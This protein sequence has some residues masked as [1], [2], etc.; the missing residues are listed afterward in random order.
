[1]KT[2]AGQLRGAGGVAG[3]DETRQ[4]VDF[5]ATHD[6]AC[7]LCGYNLRALTAPRCPECGREVR[8]SVAMA[9]PYLRAW[10][11]L[12]AATCAAGGAGM[13]LLMI[14]AVEGW[15][16]LGQSEWEHFFS[17]A[18]MVY[19]I[20]GVPLAAAVLVARR[21]LLRLTARRQWALAWA[22]VVLTTAAMLAFASL[23]R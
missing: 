13:F 11:V 17:N 12:A 5:L 22:A 4:L 6:A 19:F 9:E 15:P 14:V 1:V 20:G 10:V 23:L 3:D 8:L 18:V 16:H 21:R 2:P 7:P